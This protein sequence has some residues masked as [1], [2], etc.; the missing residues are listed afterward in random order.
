MMCR[1]LKL[2]KFSTQRAGDGDCWLGFAMMRDHMI[3][4]LHYSISNS[5]ISNSRKYSIDIIITAS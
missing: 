4:L 1:L 2:F 3:I 5:I